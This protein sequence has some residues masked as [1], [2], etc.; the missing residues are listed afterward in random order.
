MAEEEPIKPTGVRIPPDLRKW[1]KHEAVDN[2]R[3]LNS[4]IVARL[5]ES[6][7]QQEAREKA[8]E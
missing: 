7:A 4:E 5:E 8:S 3:S 2:M 1:L 6:R